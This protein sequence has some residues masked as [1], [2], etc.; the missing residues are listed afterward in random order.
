MVVGSGAAAVVDGGI[1]HISS[2][3]KANGQKYS[4]LVRR[5]VSDETQTSPPLYNDT[6][7]FPSAH[8]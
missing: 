5:S 6:T 8:Q 3:E 1:S 4:R 2:P 7:A